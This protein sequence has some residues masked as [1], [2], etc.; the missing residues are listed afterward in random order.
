MFEDRIKRLQKDVCNIRR[1]M[2][3]LGTRDFIDA[4]SDSNVEEKKCAD[5]LID[6]YNHDGLKEWMV[7]RRALEC[8]PHTQLKELALRLGI[9]R[10]WSYDRADL[11]VLIKRRQNEERETGVH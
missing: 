8:M 3:L 6:K 2:Y 4:Y 10:V 5:I 11:I 1:L 7:M 9:E